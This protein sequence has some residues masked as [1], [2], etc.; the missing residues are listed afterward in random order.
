MRNIVLK[1]SYSLLESS[2]CLQS[3][4]SQYSCAHVSKLRIARDLR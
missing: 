2:R 3:F 4:E 1:R